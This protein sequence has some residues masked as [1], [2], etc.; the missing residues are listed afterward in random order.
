MQGL[1]ASPSHGRHTSTPLPMHG[2]SAAAGVPE[3]LAVHSDCMLASGASEKTEQQQVPSQPTSHL[4]AMK[5]RGTRGKADEEGKNS[6]GG[7]A[8]GE[9]VEEPKLRSACDNCSVKKIKVCWIW[10]LAYS[11]A[12]VGFHSL[13][14]KCQRAGRLPSLSTLTPR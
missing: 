14:H 8:V 6:R 12:N 13:D 9:D 2:L 10:V 1:N 7:G 11:F 5:Q 4:Q 3:G